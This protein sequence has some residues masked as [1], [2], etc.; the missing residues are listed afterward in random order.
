[1]A[2]INVSDTAALRVLF[3]GDRNFVTASAD[4]S[5]LLWDIRNVRQAVNCLKG[6]TNLIR[7]LD[8][9][10]S[11]NKLISSSYDGSVRYWHLP[12]YHVEREDADTKETASYRGVMHR[13]ESDHPQLV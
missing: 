11:S 8:Y 12:S 10:E 4:H 6:H 9:H 1:M 7:T 13:F 3:A 5:I 2:V